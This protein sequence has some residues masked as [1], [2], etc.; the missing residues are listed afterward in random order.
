MPSPALYLG[1]PLKTFA[2]RLKAKIDSIL[3]HCRWPLHTSL[4]EGVNNKIKGIKRMA[5]GCRDDACFF[6]NTRQAFPGN[7]P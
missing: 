2:R 7:S 5:Y 4:L 3:S 1:N 6:L